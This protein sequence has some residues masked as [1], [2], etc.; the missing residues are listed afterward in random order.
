MKKIMKTVLAAVMLMAGLVGLG[1]SAVYAESLDV[2]TGCANGEFDAETCIAAGC[3]DQDTTAPGVAINLINV[4]L[5]VMGVVAIFVVAIGGVM[6]ATSG[7]SVDRISTGKHL[8]M[9]G[10][11]GLVVALLAFALVNF[12]ISAVF[13]A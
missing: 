2:C 3:S 4:V 6:Y 9:Y 13:G 5:G 7:G 1:Q 8:V 12:V 10:I 11:I